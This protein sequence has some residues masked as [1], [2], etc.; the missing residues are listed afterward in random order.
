MEVLD[1]LGCVAHRVI[2]SDGVDFDDLPMVFH[3]D[4]L[5][6]QKFLA[7]LSAPKELSELVRVL[8]DKRSQLPNHRFSRLLLK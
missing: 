8:A 5:P 4:D 1:G 6:V 2:I 7:P 3:L